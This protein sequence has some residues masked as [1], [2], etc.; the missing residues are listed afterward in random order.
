MTRRPIPFTKAD[1][2]RARAAAPGY[3]IEVQSPDGTIL[4]LVPGEKDE[5]DKA[6]VAPKKEVRL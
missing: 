6:K 1:I 4:R 2:R 5:A 3:V